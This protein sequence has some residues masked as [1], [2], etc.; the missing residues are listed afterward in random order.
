MILENVISNSKGSLVLYSLAFPGILSR[1]AEK[2]E[3]R[4]MSWLFEIRALAVPTL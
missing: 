4:T 3:N 1:Q 2:L